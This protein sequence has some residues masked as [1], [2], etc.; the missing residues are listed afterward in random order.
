MS[1]SDSTLLLLESHWAVSSIP[2]TRRQRASEVARYLLVQG[3]VGGQISLDFSLRPDDQS[4]LERV[5]MAYEIAAIEGIDALLHSSADEAN[6]SLQ[7]QAQAGAFRTYELIRALPIPTN[8]ADRAFHILHRGALAYCSDQWTDLRRWLK[9]NP[10]IVSAPSVANARWDERVLYRT[11]DC[12]I[13]LFRKN[14]WDDLDRVREIIAGLRVDQQQY[15][16]ALLDSAKQSGSDAIAY[17][18]IA[19]YHWT[20]ATEQLALYM[21]QGAPPAID[22]ELDQH[23]ESARSAAQAAADAALDVLLRWLHIASRRMV[24]S[25]IWWVARK[26]NSRVS[27]FV[28]QAAKRSMFELLPPQRAAL[29]EQGLLDQANQAVIVNLPTSGGKTVLAQFRMLQAL[30]QFADDDGWIAYVAP[31]RALVSQ[32]TR[33]LRTDFEP[34]GINVEYLS[35]SVDLDG[36]E[37]AMLQEEAAESFHVL[38]S[39]PEK[40]NLLI[41]NQVVKRP[42]ALVVMDEAHNI[43]DEDR[44]LRIELLLATIKRDCPRTNY[45]LLMPH[46]PNA[47][48]LSNWLG[49][50]S[51]RTISI[52]TSIWQPNDRVVGLFDV[53]KETSVRGGWK[54]QFE[55]LTTTPKTLHLKGHHK[56][57]GVK[58]LSISYSEAKSPTRQAGAMACV[59][60]ERGTS[61][62]VAKT[63]PHCWSLARTVAANMPVLTAI[64]PDIELAIRFLETE[65]SED[66]E[67]V[68]MLQ[69]GIGVHHAGL[70]E[71]TRA[72][73]EWLAESGKLRVLCATTTIA[74]GINFP[75]AS[76]FLASRS[77]PMRNWSRDMSK[78]A[79]WNL[80]GR[81]GRVGQDSVGVVGLAGGNDRRATIRFVQEATE[82]LVSRLVTMLREI[83]E[84]ELD[85]LTQ[86]IHHE[87]WSDF[88][89]YIAHLYNEAQDLNKTL[90]ET[91]QAL[92]NTFGYAALKANKQAGDSKLATNLLEAAKAYVRELSEHPENASLADTTGFDPE[93]VR[94]ALLEMNKLEKKLKASDWQPESLFG[95]QANSVLPQLVG[96]M[97]Q[98]PQIRKPL[99][100]IGGKG[101]DRK[102]IAALAK[103]WVSGKSIQ[104]IA[105]KYFASTDAATTNDISNAC[106]GIYR[107]LANAGTWGLAALSHMGTS[108]LDFENM[109]DEARMVV[110][111]LPAMLYHGV[112]TEAAVLMRINAVPR[113]IAIKLGEKFTRSKQGSSDVH[114][115][116][117]VRNYL[118]TLSTDDWQKSAPS[119]AKMSGTDYRDVWRLLS[120]ER[121]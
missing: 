36:C 52:G 47:K 19:L 6:K 62:A 86:V 94:T 82:E 65:I 29:Q 50:G 115:P 55:T 22:T 95:N 75:V 116:R 66:F 81:A 39:T 34:L 57:G 56:V 88:R 17:R 108:G 93:G 89:S 25:S 103:D 112:N 2:D 53:E 63:I 32:V 28:N 26:V 30:N 84:T 64:H 78:R 27:L 61:I 91:E 73:V 79:F 85:N 99:E 59:F 69:R 7:D 77:L 72:M 35:A 42:L 83:K 40:L 114:N 96:V 13:R 92:R 105:Q 41:R 118:R 80:A 16:A 49:A 110:N 87:Q 98:I 70:S 1:V 101:I 43:E 120:G 11:Y 76:V 38:V 111:N 119:H 24:A 10:G 37:R 18:L 12:W 67:L 45:L 15:E 106:R 71:E 20:K 109:S 74:Q 102:Q 46:V 60:S 121:S 31:T 58:P 97:M 8:N 5:A 68:K 3:A 23:F 21:L 104:E 9:E 54:L 51:G 117:A 100:E 107:A 48:D 14:Q 113:S 33:R 44:G 90:A 4:N